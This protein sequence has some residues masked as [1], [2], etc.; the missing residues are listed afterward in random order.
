MSN[1]IVSEEKL[2]RILFDT[3]DE[4]SDQEDEENE[5]EVDSVEDYLIDVQPDNPEEPSPST[6]SHTPRIPTSDLSSTKLKCRKRK[7]G[8][9]C[10]AD[11]EAIQKIDADHIKT[12]SNHIWHKLKNPCLPHLI[13]N[14]I[15]PGGPTVAASEATSPE[16]CFS[17]FLTDQSLAS[18]C[19][20]TNRK[21]HILRQ[22]YKVQD[23]STRVEGSNRNPDIVRGEE[24]QP[25]PNP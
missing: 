18:V 5:E 25:H 9:L 24:R 10:S 22:K 15:E 19:V 11:G 20:H 4:G 23:K 3:N 12:K 8:P 2:E 6:S 16:Q 21:I 7:R 1:K 14:R 13:T 17:L